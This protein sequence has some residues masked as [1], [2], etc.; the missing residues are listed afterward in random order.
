MNNR[1]PMLAAL[2]AA[3]AGCG[4]NIAAGANLEVTSPGRGAVEV[5]SE[6]TVTGIA[7][8]EGRGLARVEINGTRADLDATGAFAAAIDLAL[9]TQTITTT[10][11]ALDGSVATDVRAV[12][13]GDFADAG[14]IADARAMQIGPERLVRVGLEVST[15]LDNAAI[16]ADVMVG[17]VKDEGSEAGCDRDAV[18]VSSVSAPISLSLFGA[19][20]GFRGEATYNPFDWAFDAS[21]SNAGCALTTGTFAFETEELHVDFT[22]AVTGD[23]AAIELLNPAT[24]YHHEFNLNEGTLEPAVAA[25]VADGIPG[26]IATAVMSA[27]LDRIETGINAWLTELAPTQ[28]V[29]AQGES[30][31]ISY[32]PKVEGNGRGLT[33]SFDV[34]VDP[35]TVAPAFV[36]TPHDPPVLA[37]RYAAVAISDDAINQW[38]GLVWRL[39][40]FNFEVDGV[41]L[42]LMVPPHFSA[43]NGASTIVFADW[44]ATD[45]DASETV[46]LRVAVASDRD[47]D[48]LFLVAGEML[49][50]SHGI[51]S[52]IDGLEDTLSGSLHDRV[53]QAL[54][55]LRLPAG[56]YAWPV[57]AATTTAGYVVIDTAQ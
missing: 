13:V 22:L 50:E 14:S 7:T 10:A 36:S 26:D 52:R 32:A 42:E 48:N 33:V 3:A 11:Y 19:G 9:G 4:D 1:L 31:E 17:M 44:V 45:G 57:V 54:R 55:E 6:L 46:S 29:I 15:A 51:R 37:S 24:T 12:S 27:S 53:D 20:G 49:F 56:P 2:I 16:A 47:N 41:S 18:S 40:G 23:G 39:G 38:L 8:A 30:I 25:R 35:S 28:T 34:D 21:Y 43:Q 5:S